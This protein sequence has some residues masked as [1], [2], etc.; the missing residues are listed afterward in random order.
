MSEQFHSSFLNW[1]SHST[2]PCL[3]PKGTDSTVSGS[4]EQRLICLAE[5][6]GRA[7]QTSG[8]L[9]SP[10]GWSDCRPDLTWSSEWGELP[11]RPIVLQVRRRSY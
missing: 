6:P 11:S 4:L 8:R 7:R 2:S 9:V 3:V 5:R 10:A 1:Y